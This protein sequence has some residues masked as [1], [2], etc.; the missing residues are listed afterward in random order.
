MD[1]GAFNCP[2][3]L[4]IPTV[5]TYPLTSG[6][7]ELPDFSPVVDC[8]QG[9]ASLAAV[10]LW[11]VALVAAAAALSAALLSPCCSQSVV[12]PL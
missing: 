7:L 1:G 6:S 4:T 10:R 9:E 11:L 2:K 8:S 5:G 3:S 12:K